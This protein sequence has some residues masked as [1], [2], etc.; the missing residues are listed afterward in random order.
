[1]L[2]H[3]DS[4]DYSKNYTP[5]MIVDRVIQG[6]QKNKIIL[7]HCA[8]YAGIMSRMNTVRALHNIIDNLEKQGYVF[9]KVNELGHPD[10][11]SAPDEKIIPEEDDQL[12]L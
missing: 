5:K 6:A 11:V 3:I 10:S 8:D 9:V 2:W 7:L 1:M 12:N 4:K